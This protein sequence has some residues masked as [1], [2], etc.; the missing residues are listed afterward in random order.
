[1]RVS[2]ACVRVACVS[3]LTSVLVGAEHGRLG[4]E[5]R[6]AGRA[7]HVDSDERVDESHGADGRRVL[8]P[9]A[10]A[11]DTAMRQHTRRLAFV[12][13][14]RVYWETYDMEVAE[15]YGNYLPQE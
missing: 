10:R 9:A 11:G 7:I 8:V 14:G 12:P 1:M 6:D 13:S 15:D 3:L 2:H 5:S 4:R